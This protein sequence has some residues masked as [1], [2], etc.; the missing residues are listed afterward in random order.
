MTQNAKNYINP[1]RPLGCNGYLN[2]GPAAWGLNFTN[3]YVTITNVPYTNYDVI[4]YVDS[5]TSGR[6]FRLTDGPVSYFGSTL[7]CVAEV[8]NANALFLPANQ[9]NSS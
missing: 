1:E 3:S 2:A 9:T 5:D 8:E 4:V 7:G 6:R